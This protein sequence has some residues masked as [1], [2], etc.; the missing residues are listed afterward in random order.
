MEFI[1]RA[2]EQEL[3]DLFLNI[4][5]ADFNVADL[6]ALPKQVYAKIRTPGD[7][8]EPYNP[9]ANR[10]AMQDLWLDWDMRQQRLRLVNFWEWRLANLSWVLE[11]ESSLPPVVLEFGKTVI[12]SRHC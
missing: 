8:C 3:I 11:L 9:I 4:A 7:A 6:A 5:A 12:H 10:L 2:D 1:N